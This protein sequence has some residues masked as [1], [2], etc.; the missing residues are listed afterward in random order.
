M[1]LAS[2]FVAH[3]DAPLLV[4]RAATHR[5]IAT[6]GGDEPGGMRSP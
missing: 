4:E 1:T 5:R 3:H 2:A 6:E